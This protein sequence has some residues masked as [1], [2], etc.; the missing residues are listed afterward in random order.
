MGM[1][2]HVAGEELMEI[3]K[4]RPIRNEGKPLAIIPTHCACLED[5]RARGTWTGQGRMEVKGFGWSESERS[6]LQRRM[7]S[8]LATS[9]SVTPRR[10]PS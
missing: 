2:Q 10:V 4:Q 8:V 6:R 5:N 7:E 3:P 1:E 9:D